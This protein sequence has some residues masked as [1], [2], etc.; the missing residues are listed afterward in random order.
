MT[1]AKVSVAASGA[2]FDWGL[3]DDGSTYVIIASPEYA[4]LKVALDALLG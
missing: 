3:T 4:K 1:E 2:G